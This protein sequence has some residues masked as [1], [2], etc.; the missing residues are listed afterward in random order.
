[1]PG[2]RLEDR[3]PPGPQLFRQAGVLA[4]LQHLRDQVRTSEQASVENM[5]NSLGDH[6]EPRRRDERFLPR[7]SLPAFGGRDQGEVRAHD[8]RWQQGSVPRM[9]HVLSTARSSSSPASSAPPSG[10]PAAARALALLLRQ[11]EPAPA[12]APPDVGRVIG[13]RVH[14]ILARHAPGQDLVPLQ[15]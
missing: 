9:A 8:V 15:R 6:V 5:P 2:E 10:G 1:M 11:P 14:K 3:A 13:R 4:P 12:E 7:G